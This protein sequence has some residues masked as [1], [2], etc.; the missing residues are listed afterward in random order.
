MHALRRIG[1]ADEVAAA[2]EFM[3]APS[4]CFVTGQVCVCVCAVCVESA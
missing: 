1:E 4:N 2:L 3:M